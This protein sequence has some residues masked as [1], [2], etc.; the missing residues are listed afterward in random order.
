MGSLGNIE[1]AIFLAFVA[2][3]LL[4]GFVFVKLIK[5]SD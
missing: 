4:I 1:I 3:S 2:V 5:K